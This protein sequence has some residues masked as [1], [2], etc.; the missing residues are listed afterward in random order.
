MI[1]MLTFLCFDLPGRDRR[2]ICDGYK[3]QWWGQVY[4]WVRIL[5]NPPSLFIGHN[6]QAIP[7]F[8]FII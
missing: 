1:N 4:L 6:P 2:A 3:E 8:S 7:S 5:Q